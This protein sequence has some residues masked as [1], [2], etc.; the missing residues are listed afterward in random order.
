[1]GRC[2]GLILEEKSVEER[3]SGLEAREERMLST[4]DFLLGG[5]REGVRLTPSSAAAAT[6]PL[7]GIR[8]PAGPYSERPSSEAWSS[9]CCTPLQRTST[10]ADHAHGRS[11]VKDGRLEGVPACNLLPSRQTLTFC[12]DKKHVHL[13]S[14]LAKAC[15]QHAAK[16]GLLA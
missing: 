15:G 2:R 6:M 7:L 14:T 4:D 9:C 1:M 8:P 12:K 5:A 13:S 10:V 11:Q 16:R 3:S